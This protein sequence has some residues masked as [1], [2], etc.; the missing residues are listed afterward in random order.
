MPCPGGGER[1]NPLWG[2]PEQRWGALTKA[3]SITSKKG[4]GSPVEKGKKRF[5]A[6]TEKGKGRARKT[7]KKHL[8]ALGEALMGLGGGIRTSP[9]K[10]NQIVIK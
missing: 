1:K 3:R 5:L 10:K 6:I 2:K 7:R 9:N 4:R 8:G